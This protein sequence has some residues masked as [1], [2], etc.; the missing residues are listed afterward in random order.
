RPNGTVIDDVS[1]P[2]LRLN[3]RS[4]LEFL[5]TVVGSITHLIGNRPPQ[6]ATHPL[7][8]RQLSQHRTPQ[9]EHT[10]RTLQ[11]LT[12]LESLRRPI[13]IR[14]LNRHDRTSRTP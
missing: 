13:P 2:A 11:N 9:H 7:I 10:A 14:T 1:R 8:L 6:R 3:D 4:V 5:R 12:T